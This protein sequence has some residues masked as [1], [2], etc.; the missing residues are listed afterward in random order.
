MVYD[1]NSI[2]DRKNTN[3]LKYDFAVE[4]GKPEDI[5][6]LW[7]ADMDFMAP[8]EVLDAMHNAVAHGIFGY[9]DVK[10]DYFNVVHDWFLKNFQWETEEHWMIKTPGVVFALT[11]AIR[12]F[13]KEG[14]GVLIQQPVYNPFFGSI[15]SNNRKVVV[16]PLVYNNNEYTIDFE[17]FE[18]KIVSEKVKL[19]ILC[20]PH[21]PVGR[22]WTKEELTQLGDICLKHKVIVVSDEI[23]CDFIYP[24]YKHTVF[25]GINED[26]AQNTIT[27][28]APSKTFNLA[29]LQVSNIFIKNEVIRNRFISELKASGYSQCN[30]LGLVACKAAYQFGEPWLNELRAY[31]KENLDFTREYLKKNLPDIKLIEPQGTYLIWL[32]F[33][34]LK[35]T[36]DEMEK[37][38]VHSAKLW[39]NTG[40][41][42]GPNGEGFERIN[43]ACP[44]EVLKKAL[45]QL[46]AAVKVLQ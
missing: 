24:G 40:H 2:V 46:T 18:H 13:S 29:G 9:S 41:I 22:V 10:K 15:L 5:L 17:D 27:C 16:N 1:F 37:L 12:A 33:K 30:T 8:A 34:A 11:I 35:L 26:Y 45:D 39:L 43:I 7:V 19:F 42:F 44:R 23:H 6:P 25:A 3:S 31:L 28:T 14:E 20:N 36:K 32:D 4:R 38:I 21:N